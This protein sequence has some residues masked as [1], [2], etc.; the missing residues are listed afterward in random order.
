MQ[1]SDAM[2]PILGMY[3]MPTPAYYLRGCFP[4]G[5][6]MAIV[7]GKSKVGRRERGE[8]RR[9]G[10]RESGLHII[11]VHGGVYTTCTETNSHVCIRIFLSVYS[12]FTP[13]YT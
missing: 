7:K 11:R 6:L 8:G 10:R 4:M 13:L 5:D 2:N 12:D 9:K 3:K 1:V